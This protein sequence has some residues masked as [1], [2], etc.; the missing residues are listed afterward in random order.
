MP[1]LGETAAL[2][3]AF[4]W[5]FSAVSFSNA[6]RL[7]GSQPA[8]RL[9]VVLALAILILINAALYAQPIPLHAGWERWGWLSLSGVIGLALGDAF[10][11]AAYRHLGARLGL[12]LLSLAPVFSAIIAWGMYGETL[13]PL[14][15][16]GM[17]LTL[18]GIS[19]VVITR[20][21]K[22]PQH[23]TDPAKG[24]VY[25]ILAALGQAIGL[26]LSKQGMSDGFSP[27]AASLIRM[28][29]AS[30]SLWLFAILQKQAAQTLRIAR[31]NPVGLRWAILGSVV[32]PVLGVSASLLA[33]Q[34][35][36]VGITS[37]IM[38]LPPVLMMPISH[39][40]YKEHISLQAILGTVIAIAGVALLFV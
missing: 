35:A 14:Q 20:P 31:D 23:G 11:F 30:A 33:V 13:S 1:Y 28:L 36:S 39:Y 25:G 8:N 27:F 5:T 26:V 22:E 16:T 9:R 37:T 4:L 19:W 24:I 40:V 34:H 29:A 7:L 6:T 32:G 3:T 21:E 38:A 15:M 18:S 12:L 17:F 2:V 10:L